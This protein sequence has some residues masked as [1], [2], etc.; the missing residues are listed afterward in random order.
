[1]FYTC[2]RCGKDFIQ[3]PNCKKELCADCR[4]ITFTEE[5]RKTQANYTTVFSTANV[6]QPNDD[7][8]LLDVCLK[9]LIQKLI[10]TEIDE[11]ILLLLNDEKLKL[12]FNDINVAFK[13]FSARLK[14]CLLDKLPKHR[15]RDIKKIE[16]VV[17]SFLQD[18][19]K[20]KSIP[21]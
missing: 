4:Q 9:S 12:C 8:K 10:C 21:T 16:T 20:N 17:S 18:M 2:K 13:N 7:D 3:M 11:K 19:V 1:M 5:M 14:L 15:V 6:I